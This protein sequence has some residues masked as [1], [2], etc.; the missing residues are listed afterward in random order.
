[1]LRSVFLLA[2]VLGASCSVSEAFQ[3]GAARP[4]IILIL[5]D[6]LGW[7]DLGCAGSEAC[8]QTGAKT[9]KLGRSPAELTAKPGFAPCC[10]RGTSDAARA[11]SRFQSGLRGAD[12]LE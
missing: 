9:R 10:S 11:E 4:N 2:V 7:T 6:D 3:S 5:V 8:R 12:R 1:M